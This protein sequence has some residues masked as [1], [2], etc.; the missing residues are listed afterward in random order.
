MK[1]ILTTF[2]ILLTVISFMG[3]D[4]KKKSLSEGEQKAVN[5]SIEFIRKSQFTEKDRIDTSIIKIENAT[6]NT[7]EAI[8]HQNSKIDENSVDST[9]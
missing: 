7:W 8:Q 3:C 9:D 6:A 1:K 4:S 5:N 2:L